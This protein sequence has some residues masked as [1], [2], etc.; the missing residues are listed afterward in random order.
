MP[1]NPESVGS[2]SEPSTAS[3]TSKDTLLYAVSVGAGTGE[4]ATAPRTDLDRCGMR[5]TEIGC[6]GLG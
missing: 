4:L 1:L 2:V 3:W 5:I 6:H